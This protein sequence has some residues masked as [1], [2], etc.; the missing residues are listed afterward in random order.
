M[1][2]KV[3]KDSEWNYRSVSGI[4]PTW[5]WWQTSSG[6]KLQADYDFEDAYNGGNSLKFAGDLAEKYQPRRSSLLY[7]TG[8]NR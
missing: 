5:R 6:T 3:S 4:L 7:K 2:G 1:D 8:S